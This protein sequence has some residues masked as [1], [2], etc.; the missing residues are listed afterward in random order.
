LQ[1]ALA[2]HLCSGA[3]SYDNYSVRLSDPA[4]HAAVPLKRLYEGPTA[5][6]ASRSSGRVVDALLTHMGS[7]AL[8]GRPD[9]LEVHA[10]GAVGH[11]R[12]VLLP[13]FLG[14]HVPA[15]ERRLARAGY[16][17][18]DAP[19]I[20]LDVRSGELVVPETP[21][22]VDRSALADVH[23]RDSRPATEGARVEPGRYPIAC[24]ALPG[25]GDGS[26]TPSIAATALQA[27]PLARRA[28]ETDAQP[29]IE[30]LVATLT[31]AERVFVAGDE[32]AIAGAVLSAVPSHDR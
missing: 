31:S 17:L 2:D 20:H 4:Q 6:L 32:A 24:W 9:L 14:H 10:V 15:L 11:G 8:R 3:M 19:S 7:W 23:W 5:R 1:A 13:A 30:T 26:A 25:R 22:R 18:L 28:P 27:A 29:V 16:S 21:L 12:A